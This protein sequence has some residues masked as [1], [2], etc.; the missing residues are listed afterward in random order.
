[1]DNDD[2]GFLNGLDDLLRRL[3]INETT[4]LITNN[5]GIEAIE[6]KTYKNGK[7]TTISKSGELR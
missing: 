4:T 2:R 6:K 7:V 1:M 3:K 5:N